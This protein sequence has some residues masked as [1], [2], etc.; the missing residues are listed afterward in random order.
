MLLSASV[1]F[2]SWAFTNILLVHVHIDCTY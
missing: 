1:K 2:D